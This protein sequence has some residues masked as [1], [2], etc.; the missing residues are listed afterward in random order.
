MQK[1][2][3]RLSGHNTSLALEKEFWESLEIIAATQNTT[4]VDF[5]TYQDCHRK[6]INLASHLRVYA[7]NY[8]KNQCAPASN[9]C[10][11]KVNQ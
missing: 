4:L 2:S 10:P 8:Y 7:L 5:I 3:I 11:P 9:E 6:D 1:K